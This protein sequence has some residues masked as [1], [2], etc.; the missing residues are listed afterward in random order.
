MKWK[1]GEYWNVSSNNVAESWE[2]G[3]CGGVALN[4]R[5]V[6]S[7]GLIGIVDSGI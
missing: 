6:D 1:H 7:G 4:G 3:A 5:I 2:G